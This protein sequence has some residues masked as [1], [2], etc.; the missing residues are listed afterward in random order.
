MGEERNNAVVGD[1]EAAR[2][3]RMFN[4]RL[5]FLQLGNG[6]QGRRGLWLHQGWEAGLL[7]TV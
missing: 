6:D 1:M 4:L 7:I 2:T 3:G 5:L